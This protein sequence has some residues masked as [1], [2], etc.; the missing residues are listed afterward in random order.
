MLDNNGDIVLQVGDSSPQ[1]GPLKLLCQFL[2]CHAIPCHAMMPEKSNSS[3]SHT[4]ST[5][6]ATIPS[7][8]DHLLNIPPQMNVFNMAFF[9]RKKWFPMFF[10]V[11]EDNNKH[12][13]W[14]WHQK[15]ITSCPGRRASLSPALSVF[16]LSIS[17]FT[18]LHAVTPS[19]GRELD[20]GDLIQGFWIEDSNLQNF[21]L[22]S[23]VNAI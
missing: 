18:L 13:Q 23:S 17:I 1:Y 12:C 16:S 19:C 11:D 5:R 14:W 15:T 8:I 3:L 6:H 20:R 21:F 22:F 2:P 4:P 9:F 10:N 7:S